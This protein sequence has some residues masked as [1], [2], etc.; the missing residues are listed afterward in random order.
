MTERRPADPPPDSDPVTAAPPAPQPAE[1]TTTRA[2][3]P[4]PPDQPTSDAGESAFAAAFDERVAELA[5]LY[6]AA[7]RLLTGGFRISAALLA[8]GLLIAFVR[9]E[10]LSEEAEPL[11]KIFDLIRD[12]HG[13]GLVDLAIVAMVLTPVATVVVIAIG[14]LRLGDR[15]YA[16]AS[17]VV[18]AIL[19]VSVTVSLLR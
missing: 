4:Q 7:G 8:A 1:A 9:D 19:A 12:G 18:L 16:F 14:F 5:P 6:A 13:A 11:P 3:P 10:R 2:P 15:R 17:F